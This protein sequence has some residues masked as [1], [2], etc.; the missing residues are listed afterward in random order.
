MSVP[1][2]EESLQ[3]NMVRLA[4]IEA[5]VDSMKTQLKSLDQIPMQL[6]SLNTTLKILGMVIALLFPVACTW[7]YYLGNLLTA[8]SVRVSVLEVQVTNLT[9]QLKRRGP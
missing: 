5:T 9:E 4:R 6:G 7:N 2:Q 1:V 3:L 8:Q